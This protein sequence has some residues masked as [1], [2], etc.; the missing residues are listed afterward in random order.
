M[1]KLITGIQGSGKSYKAMH[2]IATS[3]DK[4]Y[5]VYSNLDKLINTHTIFSLDFNYFVTYG[6]KECFKIM[7]TNNRDMEVNE[8]LSNDEIFKLI[9]TQ[10]VSFD[11]AIDHLKEIGIL[12]SVVNE[13]N[14]ILMI[15]DEAQDYF[16]KSA[17]LSSELIWF[18]TQH[19]HLYIEVILLTQDVSLIRSDYKLFNE[20]YDAVPPVKQFDKNYFTYHQY[21]GLP[22]SEGNYV[23]KIKLKRDQKI[24]A[25]YQSGDKVESPNILKRFIWM[26]VAAV[27]IVGVSLYLLFDQFGGKK[28]KVTE[29]SSKKT[30]S[31]IGDTTSKTEI[32]IISNY[33]DFKYIDLHCMGSQC[34]NK[35]YAINVQVDD[36]QDLLKNTQSKFLRKKMLS[37]NYALV[38]LLVSPDFLGLFKKGSEKNE[39]GFSFIN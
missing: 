20:I 10:N 23:G 31:V 17:K 33:N 36:L 9:T 27:L 26:A 16:G 37:S 38:Y 29:N 39:K 11:D 14:R 8:E 24:F 21:A 32:H 12:P 34:K 1:A 35:K 2:E 15:I 13:D 22:I 19:R 25:M 6:L 30:V 18:I 28:K 3:K 4:Y 7:V 5:R